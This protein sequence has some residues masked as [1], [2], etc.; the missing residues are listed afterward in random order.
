MNPDPEFHAKID[1]ER[2]IGREKQQILN[3]NGDQYGMIWYG[4]GSRDA[5]PVQHLV[6]SYEAS[7]SAE[8]DELFTPAHQKKKKRTA[9]FSSSPDGEVSKVKQ[10]QKKKKLT[11]VKKNIYNVLSS[12]LLKKTLEEA[13]NEDTDSSDEGSAES[14]DEEA[15]ENTSDENENDCDVT[16]HDKNEETPAGG[17]S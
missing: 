3:P 5:S 2:R 10:K 14:S 12:K 13:D 8:L 1:E 7:I 11:E 17:S 4:T 15:V 6:D 16:V 9:N